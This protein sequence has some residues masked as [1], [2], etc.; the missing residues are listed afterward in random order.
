MTQPKSD[1]G[2]I[3]ATSNAHSKLTQDDILC[4]L[5]RHVSGD[6]GD[7]CEEDRQENEFSL[8]EGFRILSV[9]RGINDI[10]FWIITEA[11]RSV[12]TVLL[13]EDY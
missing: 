7:V 6:W 9:Y 12:T 2:Q 13:P 11:D 1:L 5:G 3:V 8:K 4:A 10:K